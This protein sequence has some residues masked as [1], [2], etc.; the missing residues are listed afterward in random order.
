MLLSKNLIADKH[1]AQTANVLLSRIKA[2]LQKT[3]LQYNANTH[4]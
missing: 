3:A 2:F 4:K 1:A